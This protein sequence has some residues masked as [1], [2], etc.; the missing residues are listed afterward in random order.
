[1]KCHILVIG[2]GGAGLRAAIAARESGA[3]VVLISKSRVGYAN[4][5][6]ISKA[7][8]AVSGLGRTADGP[9]VHLI[10]TVM[11]GRFLNDQGL[12]EAMTRGIRPQV[13]FLEKCGVRFSMKDGE[14][15][16]H[17]VPG[18]SHARHILAP[19]RMGRDLVLPLREKAGK[20]GVRFVERAIASRL[21]ARNGRVAGATALSD[22]GTFL[23]VSAGC[24]I[25]ASG[26][27]GQVFLNNNNAPGITGDG[28]SLA[29]G[30]GA[31]LK[32]MEF[33]QFYP[34][35]LGRTGRSILLY[36]SLVV[37]AG[38]R[39]LNS[40]G[41]DVLEKHG[42]KDPM[43]LTRDRLARSIMM[44]IQEGLDVQGGVIM[45]LTAVPGEL[46]GQLRPLLPTAWSAGKRKYI[47]SPTVHFCMGGVSI[48][49]DTETSVPGL[50]AS[51][52]V[53]AGVHGANRLGG[54]SLSEV[55]G[56][57]AL[58]GTRA[59]QR[60][61]TL[62]PQEIPP[63]GRRE[64]KGRLESL[65]SEKGEDLR[66]LERQLK[67]AMWKRAG[68]V[69]HEKGLV[70]ALEQ[71]GDHK[72]I[73]GGI[74]IGNFRDLTRYLEYRNLLLVSEMVCRASLLRRESRGSH[75]RSDYPEEDNV[76]WLKNIEIQ[77]DPLGMRLEPVPVRMSRIA[78]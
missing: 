29:F 39:L 60:Q 57:G 54:N 61:E 27:Y 20:I 30:L 41:E 45:D 44:E 46:E 19:S 65:F 64:E 1:M 75:Y 77:K 7:T 74:K 49:R 76:Q 3:E 24:I 8:F 43:L 58:S 22:E 5:T 31:R 17:S 56:M 50:F 37:R 47:V 6:Y 51:G 12:A 63:D 35:A 28:Q 10:D 36:E 4:N 14:I 42:L 16:L 13:A 73:A 9:G 55:F 72:A 48:D 66:A 33:V 40:R 11:G 53:C 34:T 67:E 32:D 21:F 2:G 52:E 23:S 59:A 62:E 26:G 70:E 69:R 18:H 71:I 38:G 78:P 68:I 25:L 15:Q